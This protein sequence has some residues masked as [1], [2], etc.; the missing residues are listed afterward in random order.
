MSLRARL[1]GAA[2]ELG[3]ARAGLCDAL[4]FGRGGDA[5][6]AWLANGHHGDMA[7]MAHPDRRDPAVAAHG[8]RSILVVACA[9]GGE[10]GPV[11]RYA[12]GEDY[13]RVVRAKLDEL[14]RLAGGGRP[15]VDTAPVLE[16][17]AAMRA[18]VAF[19]GKS[20]LAIVPGHGSYVLLG[21]LLLDRAL[22]ADPPMRP[23]CGRCTLCLDACPTR[24]F[25]GPFELD[26]RRCISYLT[27]EHRGIIARHL[28][29]LVGS[30][31]FGCDV[32]QEVCPYNATG[33]PRL[34]EAR[35]DGDISARLS[36]PTKGTPGTGRATPQ[37]ELLVR[38]LRSTSGDYRRLTRGTALAR[39][40]REQLARNAAVA[41]GNAGDASAAGALAEAAHGHRSA[42]VRAHAVWALHRLGLDVRAFVV[43]ED[44]RVR[45][46]TRAAQQGSTTGG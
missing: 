7:Y 17:E 29:P 30:R 32:C 13:H 46:E 28:R 39:T 27:I 15:C 35:L 43:D 22:P 25:V 1:L 12:R 33:K 41:L 37:V 23:R 31:V 45:A 5:L 3:F 40:S 42:L 21:E 38:L 10:P 19:I 20:T 2:R 14:A 24:A 44:E 4:P 26:A 18:G 16:R 34:L 11:A 36:H 9:Y 8:A 6:R